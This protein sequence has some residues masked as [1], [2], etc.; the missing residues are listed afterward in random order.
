MLQKMSTVL[1]KLCSLKNPEKN[2]SQKST[3]IL[4]STTVFSIEIVFPDHVTLMRL[5]K[6]QLCHHR[7]K[8][9]YLI[10]HIK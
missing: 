7:N 2:V 3:K 5:L 1:N 9:H 6:T 8:L 10:L 4:S